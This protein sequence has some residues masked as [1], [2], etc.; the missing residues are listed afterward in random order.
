MGSGH[1]AR[2]MVCGVS[3]DTGYEVDL[4]GSSTDVRQV[5]LYLSTSLALYLSTSSYLSTPLPHNLF[6]SL[7][8]P[9]PLT[10]FFFISS[11]LY[12]STQTEAPI[13]SSDRIA[14]AEPSLSMLVRT[15]VCVC[16]VTRGQRGG[17]RRQWQGGG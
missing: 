11:P 5:A 17:A 13:E 10:D 6:T 7:P 8:L 2:D 12:L 9:T 4:A 1:G 16:V 3:V 15:C 14:D